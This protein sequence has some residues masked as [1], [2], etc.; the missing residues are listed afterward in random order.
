[1]KN[2]QLFC[3]LVI[4]MSALW[5]ALTPWKFRSPGFDIRASRL[6]NTEMKRFSEEQLYKLIPSL[7]NLCYE[8]RLRKLK[9]PSLWHRRRRGDMIQV[10][11]ITSGIDRID[12]QL[13]FCRPEKSSTRGHSQ[14]LTKQHSRTDLRSKSFR[15]KDPGRLEL[16]PRRDSLKQ[17][18]K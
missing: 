12:P 7:R 5:W 15:A 18:T 8:D 16:T 3:S 10:Y 17:D 14:K 1:M 13:F 9:L 4:H 6:D 2:W 11:K